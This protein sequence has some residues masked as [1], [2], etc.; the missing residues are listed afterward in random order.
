MVYPHTSLMI[1]LI[2]LFV[3]VP[4]FLVFRVLM[5][6]YRKAERRE[7]PSQ[8]YFLGA[9]FALMTFLINLGILLGTALGIRNGIV[10]I[11]FW[12]GVAVAIAWVSFWAWIFLELTIARKLGRRRP[13]D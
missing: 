5:R 3:C 4:P 9:A 8:R 6:C 12:Q 11:G 13:N 7:I 10:E 2:S 1:L